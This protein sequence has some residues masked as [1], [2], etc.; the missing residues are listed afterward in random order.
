MSELTRIGGALGPGVSELMVHP[1]LTND[2]RP[3]S[4]DYDWRGDLA[5]VTHYRKAEFEARFEVRLVSYREAWT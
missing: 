5:A 2:D 3:F 4:I 1:G